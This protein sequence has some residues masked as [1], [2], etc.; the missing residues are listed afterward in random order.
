MTSLLTAANRQ[1][2][3]SSFLRQT[4]NQNVS[5]P[6]R[7]IKGIDFV[8]CFFLACM[9][10]ERLQSGWRVKWTRFDSKLTLI[11][12]HSSR[13]PLLS[14]R[15]RV[16][17]WAPHFTSAIQQQQQ[18]AEFL[19][20][21]RD[22]CYHLLVALGFSSF[23]VKFQRRNHTNHLQLWDQKVLISNED[24]LC[25][26]T[27]VAVLP[28]E[29]PSIKPRPR[30]PDLSLCNKKRKC[31]LI[32]CSLKLIAIDVASLVIFSRQLW[33]QNKDHRIHAVSQCGSIC[34]HQ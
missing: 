4:K 12:T 8:S 17:C 18:L 19:E 5:I 33:H 2:L 11:A 28:P 13:E 7:A 21:H 34:S 25:H 23:S 1:W 9:A 3:H 30:V 26:W 10:S 15:P 14:S 24:R 32:M 22:T 31:V 16:T 29:A 6:A 20:Q 27:V